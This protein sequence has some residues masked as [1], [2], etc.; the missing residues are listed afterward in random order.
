VQVHDEPVERADAGQRVALNL[1]GLARDEIGRGDVVVA[2]AEAPG[3][4]FRIDAALEWASPDARP[5]TGARIGVHHGTRETA[6]RLVDLGGRFFQ[7]RLERELVPARGDRLVIRSLAPPDTLGGGVVLDP[8]PRRHGPSRDLLVRLTRLERGEDPEP[9]AVPAMPKPKAP[10]PEPVQLTPRQQK[11]EERL[12]AA[13]N[14]PPLD[15]E[16]DAGDLAALRSAGRVVRLGANMHIHREPLAAVEDRVV[17]LVERDGEVT[18]ASLRD[19]LGTSRKYAQ[20]LLEHCDAA[21]I[22][23]RVGDRRVLR[24]RSGG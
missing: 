16:L 5:E 8:Q 23:L 20:A 12:R 1:V 17:E 2:G 24:R 19:D 7:L 11:L 22:T 9:A 10:E 13:G 4:S 3:A 21:R 18:I 15:S 6:A 14:T